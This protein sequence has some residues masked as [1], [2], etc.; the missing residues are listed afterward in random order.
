MMDGCQTYLEMCYRLPIHDTT[1][2][3]HH[4]ASDWSVYMFKL[5][6]NLSSVVRMTKANCVL[7]LQCIVM[8]TTVFSAFVLLVFSESCVNKM[9][10]LVL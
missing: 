3:F 9:C 2:P 5:F 7:N 10:H 4:L 6:K 8:L 1:C